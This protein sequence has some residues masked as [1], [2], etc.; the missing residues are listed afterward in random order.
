MNNTVTFTDQHG[1]TLH[2]ENGHTATIANYDPPWTNADRAA[3]AARALS[4]IVD[5]NGCDDADA[6]IDLLADIRHYC[7]Q[8]GIDYTTADTMAQTHFIAETEEIE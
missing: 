1:H 8:H 6:V 7:H 3:R 2:T 5:A 4:D